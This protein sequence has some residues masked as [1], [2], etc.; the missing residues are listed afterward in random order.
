LA[1]DFI[2]V[3]LFFMQSSLWGKHHI[4]HCWYQKTWC[5]C[6]SKHTVQRTKPGWLWYFGL[7][8]AR[9]STTC[10][11]HLPTWFSV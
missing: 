8:H 5:I 4:L 11:C 3:Y 2:S 9:I 6:R 10:N 1:T 7:Y